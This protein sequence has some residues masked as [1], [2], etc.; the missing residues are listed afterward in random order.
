MEIEKIKTKWICN[1]E[2]DVYVRKGE[3]FNLG[4][5]FY[6]YKTKKFIASCVGIM[7]VNSGQLITF[8]NMFDNAFESFRISHRSSLLGTAL[9]YLNED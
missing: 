9:Y 3:S 2:K 8:T 5:I 6:D 1:F 4:L 7:G